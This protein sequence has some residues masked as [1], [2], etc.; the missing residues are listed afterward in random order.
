MDSEEGTRMRAGMAD[1]DVDLKPEDATKNEILNTRNEVE[2]KMIKV[3]ED[4]PL[5]P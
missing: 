1:C 3:S 5:W 4:V 2:A